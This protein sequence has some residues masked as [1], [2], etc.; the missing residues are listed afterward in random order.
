ME[1]WDA[2]DEN[3]KPLGY[4]VKREKFD[5]LNNEYHIVV[6]IW[7]KNSNGE[8]LIQKRSSNKKEGLKWAWTGGSVL[9]GENSIDGAV[10]EVKE[11]LGLTVDKEK[12]TLFTSYK[13][14]LYKDFVDVYIYK[15][16]ID[17]SK[18]TLQKDEV[19]D[20]KWATKDEISQMIL[21]GEFINTDNSQYVNEILI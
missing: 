13:R 6:H 3:R 10:R 21:S 7:I 20:V 16:D 11:E 5:S 19:C 2:Y 14:E 4:T 18:L 9:M 12:L 1:L 8:Y 15:N 17:V